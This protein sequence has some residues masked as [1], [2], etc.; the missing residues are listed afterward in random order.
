MYL[1]KTTIKDLNLY[2]LWFNEPAVKE[3]SLTKNKKVSYKD[4]CDWFSNTLSRDDVL[5]YTLVRDL[6]LVGQIRVEILKNKKLLINYSIGNKYRQQGYG[7]KII[8][9]VIR[10]LK[11][12]SILKDHTFL[13]KVK[14]N[15]IGSN[16]IFQRLNFK[17]RKY[18]NLIIYT[19]NN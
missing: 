8:E 16:K 14:S 1:R 13:A 4:H 10:K 9:L 12:N 19:T 11:I 5:M 2:W 6:V 7:K 17:Q 15:N 3:N 18:K